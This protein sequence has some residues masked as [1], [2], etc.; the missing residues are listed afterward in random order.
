MV[1]FIQFFYAYGA[2]RPSFRLVN[3]DICT[4]TMYIVKLFRALSL[5][6]AN[7]ANLFESKRP[8]FDLIAMPKQTIKLDTRWKM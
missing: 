5:L 1:A 7:K 6:C 2:W 3:G 8:K 4:S